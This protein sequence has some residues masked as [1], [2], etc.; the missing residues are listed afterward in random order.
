MPEE[1]SHHEHRFYKSEEWHLA[2][3]LMHQ[4]ESKLIK[5][6]FKMTQ[7]NESFLKSLI[8]MVKI[9]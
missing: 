7:V 9:K 1:F 8:I 3:C 5:R 6:L 4:L 2:I